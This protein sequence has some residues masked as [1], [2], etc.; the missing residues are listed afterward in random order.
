[1]PSSRRYCIE[2]LDYEPDDDERALM[3]ASEADA[4]CEEREQDE[5]DAARLLAGELRSDRAMDPGW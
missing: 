2:V 4:W 1:M 3:L 5:R